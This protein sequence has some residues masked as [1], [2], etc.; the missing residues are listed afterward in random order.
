[1]RLDS[2]LLI[3]QVSELKPALQAALSQVAAGD[4]LAIDCGALVELDGA[5]VQLLVTAAQALKT[6]EARLA[7]RRCTPA[8]QRQIVAAGLAGWFVFD[9]EL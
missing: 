5:G 3:Y 8:I 7:L 9:G 4:V 2:E 1:M 6:R